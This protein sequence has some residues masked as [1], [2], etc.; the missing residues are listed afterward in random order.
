[1]S[2]TVHRIQ[3]KDKEIILIGTAHVSKNSAEEVKQVIEE[4]KPDSV[5]IELC[6]SRY[7]SMQDQDRWKKTDIA[8]VIKDKKS[9]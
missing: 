7:Q 2:E 1:M 9:F 3:L 4:E 8:K 5:A 6:N